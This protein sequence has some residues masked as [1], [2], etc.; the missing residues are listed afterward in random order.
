MFSSIRIGYIFLFIGFFIGCDNSGGTSDGDLLHIA[1]VP[2]DYPVMIPKGLPPLPEVPENPQTVDG[3][4]LGRHLFFDPILSLD[5][6]LSCSGCHD[7]RKAFTDNLP[8]SPGVGGTLG[9]RSSMTVLNTAYFVKGLFWDG[10]VGTL[11]KQAIEPVQN[12]VEMHENW[13]RVVDKLRRHEKYPE[14]F[15]K[16]FGI[17]DRSEISQELAAKAIAQYE[18]LALTGGQSL[19]QR[20]LRGEVFFDPDQQEGHDL[21]FNAD[22]L[23]PDAECF[24]CHAAPLMHAN[25][26]FNNGIDTV[27][28]LDDF[29]DKG[30]GQFTGLNIDNGKFKAPTLYNIELTAPYMHDGR[31]KTLEEVIEHYNSGGHFAKNKDGFVRPLGLNKSQKKSLL[32]FLRTLTDTSYLKNPDIFSPF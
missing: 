16:A 22:L 12:P 4:L 13:P 32:A 31:F 21:Y 23:I 24:H 25:D 14:L 28:S 11:E 1:Y 2:K 15:R 26:F 20:Q 9:N 3:V 10:R 8:V 30:R 7:P 17:S 27:V 29:Q 18:R 6:T 5:S 19:Y